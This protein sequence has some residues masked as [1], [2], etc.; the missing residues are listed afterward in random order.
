MFIEYCRWDDKTLYDSTKCFYAL[1]N[2]SLF[3]DTR[4]YDLSNDINYNVPLPFEM[5]TSKLPQTQ[6]ITKTRIEILH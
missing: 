6:E 4:F 2:I 5:A 1:L 3:W